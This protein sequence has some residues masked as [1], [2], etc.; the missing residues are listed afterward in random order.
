MEVLRGS[1]LNEEISWKASAESN[2]SAHMVIGR[3]E[4]KGNVEQKNKSKHNAKQSDQCGRKGHKTLDSRY[5]KKEQENW[6]NV[7]D[8]KNDYK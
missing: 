2:S 6:K 4:K 3:S 1:I 7:D 5:N 8:K